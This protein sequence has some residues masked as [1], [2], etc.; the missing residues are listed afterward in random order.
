[1]YKKSAHVYMCVCVLYGPVSLLRGSFKENPWGNQPEAE[2]LW[3]MVMVT[4]IE[5][6]MIV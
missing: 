5:A 1:M 2:L 3:T 6:F 4:L